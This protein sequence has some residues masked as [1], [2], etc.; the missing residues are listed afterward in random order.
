[1]FSWR[2]SDSEIS[3]ISSDRISIWLDNWHCWIADV[4]LNFIP[5][6][7]IEIVDHYELWVK[8]RVLGRNSGFATFR[9]RRDGRILGNAVW[10]VFWASWRVLRSGCSNTS[11]SFILTETIKARDSVER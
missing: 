5:K 6:R 10:L 8:T 9:G 11:D 3:M 4:V 7:R 2:I 1:M